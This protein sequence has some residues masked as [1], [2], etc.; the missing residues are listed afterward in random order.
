[1][2][3]YTYLETLV[4]TQSSEFFSVSASAISTLPVVLKPIKV[5][6]AINTPVAILIGK[7]LVTNPK[8]VKPPI[9]S[10]EQII[11]SVKRALPHFLKL[12]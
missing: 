7:L 6:R 1:M 4:L 9:I 5:T 12:L 8:A 10:N 11:E 3:P 2:L